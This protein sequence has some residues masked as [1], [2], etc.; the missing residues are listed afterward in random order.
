MTQAPRPSP[1]VRRHLVVGWG[2]VLVFLSLGLVLE[3]LHGFKVPAYLDVGNETRRLLWTLAHAHGVLLGVLH[4][5]LAAT[6]SAV[7][8]TRLG[9]AGRSLEAASVLLPGGF[10]LG[11]FDIR[12]GD[13]GLGVL[14]V[15]PGG[16]LL[17]AAVAFVLRAVLASEA[18]SDDADG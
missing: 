4:L 7:G 1:F 18:A 15:P 3:A 14:L 9:L 6:A 10:F 8:A 2:L 5:G 17:L 16:V 11:G 13:P 12:G